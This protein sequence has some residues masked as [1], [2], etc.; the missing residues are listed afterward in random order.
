M[1]KYIMIY[2]PDAWA[3]DPCDTPNECWEEMTSQNDDIKP[4]EVE[5]F[6][7]KRLEFTV[8]TEVVTKQVINTVS[9]RSKP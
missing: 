1:A 4:D 8:K 5:L 2:S 9:N 3:T 7:V 6:E